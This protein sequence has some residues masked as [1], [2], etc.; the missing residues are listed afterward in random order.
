[1]ARKKAGKGK[2]AETKA[3][4]AQERKAKKPETKKPAEKSAAAEQK[5]A[6]SRRQLVTLIATGLKGDKAFLGAR[7]AI[8]LMKRNALSEVVYST[9]IPEQLLKDLSYYAKLSTVILTRFDGDSRSLGEL[10]G[11]PFNVLVVGIAK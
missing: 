9:N 8:K 2:E 1:M 10:C 3:K 6:R 4:A 5:Q 7:Q 11:R